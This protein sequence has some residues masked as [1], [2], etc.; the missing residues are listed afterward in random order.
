M[1]NT[2][3]LLVREGRG[4][5]IEMTWYRYDK[6]AILALLLLGLGIRLQG[7]RLD[8][9]DHNCFRGATEAMMARHFD[10][11][12]L[13]LQYPYICGYASTPVKFVNEF[14]LYPALMAVTYR[15]FGEDILFG[16][17]ISIVASLGTALLCYL[18]LRHQFSNSTPFWGMLLFTLSPL[19]SYVGRCVLRHPTA[20]FFMALAFF[21]WMLWL[22]RSSWWLWL[23]V[24]FSAAASILM[25]F[26]NAYIGLPM[27][28]ALI[29]YRGWRGI[30]DRRVWWLAVLVLLPTFLWVYHAMVS[31][32]WFMTPRGTSQRE[33]GKFF[34]L[35]WW[36]PEFFQ[37]LGIHLWGMLLTPSGVILASLGLFLFWR[38]RFPWV[39]RVWAATVFLYFAYDSYAVS[40]EIHD[41]YFLHALFPACLAAGI[42]GGTL[43]DVARVHARNFPNL[44]SL[45]MACLLLVP[46]VR[47]WQSVDIPL[48]QRFL[49]EEVGWLKHWLPASRAIREKTEADAVVVVDREVESLIYLCDRPGWVINYRDLHPDVLE[50]MV[51]Q[52]GDYLL[53]T[54]YT[55]GQD[56]RFTGYQ[57]YTD[58]PGAS[59]VQAHGAVIEDASIYQIVDLTPAAHGR[60]A[61][62]PPHP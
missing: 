20:F 39:V 22:E 6:W 35:E 40:V 42:A 34:R 51:A 37:N 36:N 3:S 14:P 53:I 50:K 17:L 38:S 58:S 5:S 44:A 24:W 57:F 8:L 11:H 33:P 7:I 9:I 21:L 45:A 55:M 10:R 46:M 56:G 1:G 4:C 23:G 29:L 61:G 32:A 15:F 18:I 60:S 48:K 41:Y 30:L 19:G 16:R 28:A 54:T 52:G 43:V 27:L 62:I 31:G 26:P 13:V 47:N 2:S 12:G 59:W 49:V 25:N